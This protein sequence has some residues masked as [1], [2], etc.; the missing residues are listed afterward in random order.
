MDK[1]NGIK[2]TGKDGFFIVRSANVQSNGFNLT[3]P[4]KR[5]EQLSQHTFAMLAAAEI[6]VDAHQRP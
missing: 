6:A 1:N 4:G 2:K 5:K 3:I